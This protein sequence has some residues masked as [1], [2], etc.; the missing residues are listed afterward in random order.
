MEGIN[1]TLEKYIEVVPVIRDALGMDIMMSITDG[2]E[3]LGYWK[4]DKMVADIHVGDKLS[5][6][7]PMWEVFKTGRKIQ[8]VMP[9][10]VYGFEFN[11]IMI[12]IKEY[13]KVVG[14]LG[15]AVSLENDSF[16]KT[17]SSQLLACVSSVQSSMVSMEEENDLIYHS[18]EQIKEETNSIL[19][20]TD[21]IFEYAKSIQ[22]I[23]NDTNMLS[24]NASI[25][26]ARSGEAGK[27]FNVVANRMSELSKDTTSASKEIIGLLEE[28]RNT[29]NEMN[30]ALLKQQKA[31]DKQAEGARLLAEYASEIES[32]TKNLISRIK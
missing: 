18:S 8:T 22:K 4:G 1:A 11:A 6:D 15:I 19:E 23:A 17:M 3:F 10:S 5:H 16:T 2:N 20:N 14:T 32:L 12:P 9:A 31:H 25:E 30:D 21:K 26:A 13:G 7:D 24:L 29:A 27:G 28:F